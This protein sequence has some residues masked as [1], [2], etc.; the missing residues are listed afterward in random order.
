MNIDHI[1]EE[2]VVEHLLGMRDRWYTIDAILEII[3]ELEELSE[4]FPSVFFM[5]S[6]I[7]ESKLRLSSLVELKAQKDF[8]ELFPLGSLHS[9]IKG[10]I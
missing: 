6:T 2:T 10:T 1:T 5:E 9:L 7:Y 8:P 4:K 3:I